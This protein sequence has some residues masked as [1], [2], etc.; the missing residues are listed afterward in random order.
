VH[1]RTIKINLQPDAT[2]FQFIILKFIYSLTCFRLCPAH[3]QEI[4][5]CSGS[6]WFY[7]RKAYQGSQEKNLQLPAG[8]EP[9]IPEIERT[10]THNLDRAA[11]GIGKA[12]GKPS[13]NK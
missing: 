5:D 2:V 1:H 7:L 6:L 8:F 11:T 13:K 4:N 12:S 10:Q 3:H 9:T